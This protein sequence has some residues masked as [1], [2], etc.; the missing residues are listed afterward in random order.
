MTKLDRTLRETGCYMPR[1]IAGSPQDQSSRVK[2][3][4][5]G[6]FNNCW[7]FCWYFFSATNLNPYS[8]RR[9]GANVIPA[10]AP[11]SDIRKSQTL[12]QPAW[13]IATAGFLLPQ[14]APRG[15]MTYCTKAVLLAVLF[16][17]RR[18]CG[19]FL[20]LIRPFGWATAHRQP[21][22]ASPG[23][24]AWKARRARRPGPRPTRG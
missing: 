10:P 6:H 15:S 9:E 16:K 14:V 24:C 12:S 20:R 4:T 1:R 22:A 8:T 17:C 23:S 2:N 18:H 21:G 7:Y 13:L 19:N 5:G 3:P 11:A